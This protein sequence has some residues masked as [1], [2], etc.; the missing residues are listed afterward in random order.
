MSRV[1]A[2]PRQI[3]QPAELPSAGS[4]RRSV[5]APATTANTASTQATN[6]SNQLTTPTENAATQEQMQ[7]QIRLEKQ[8]GSQSRVD[9]GLDPVEKGDPVSQAEIDWAMA[10]EDKV[11]KG[12]QP[13]AKEVEKYTDIA[14]RLTAANP[15][16]QMPEETVS[17]T[18]STADLSDEVSVQELEWAKQLEFRV[19]QGYR[20][21]AQ[22]TALYENIVERLQAQQLTEQDLTWARDLETRIQNGY[23]PS[24]DEVQQYETIFKRLQVQQ[25]ISRQDESTAVEK[26]QASAQV[27]Q[28]ELQWAQGVMQ[29]VQQGGPELTPKEIERYTDIYNRAQAGQ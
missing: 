27:S 1:P 18:E 11:I 19:K 5:S 8:G 29:R 12:Y 9:L 4:S 23:E 3:S 17:E 16:R 6:P 2:S 28:E 22:E 7:D 15:A 26:T 13:S 10:L 20:P 25:G 21:N 14:A 24:A